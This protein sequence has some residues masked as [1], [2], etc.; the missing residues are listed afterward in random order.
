MKK[1]I[2]F[3]PDGPK[4]RIYD[5][6]GIML[7]EILLKDEN[8]DFQDFLNTLFQAGISTGNWERTDWGFQ[9]EILTQT[10]KEG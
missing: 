2:Q 1:S 8:A 6:Y 3:F 5:R 4:G 10:H 7:L 9:G